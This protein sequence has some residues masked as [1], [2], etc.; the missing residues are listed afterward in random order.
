[1]KFIRIANPE[2]DEG[3]DLETDGSLLEP[4]TRKRTVLHERT[5]SQS[6]LDHPFHCATDM[7]VHEQDFVIRGA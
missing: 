1:M 7:A 5:G 2:Q 3:S 6:R 4:T